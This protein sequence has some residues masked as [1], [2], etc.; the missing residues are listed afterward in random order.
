MGLS[1]YIHEESVH[2]LRDPEIIVPV[3]MEVLHPQS[4]VDVGCG[5]GTFLHV[6][7]K[8]GV[9]KILGI[10]GDWVNKEQIAKHIKP[11]KFI[12]VDLE[13]GIEVD[14]KFDLAVCL[15]V[16]EHLEEIHADKIVKNLT[17]LS[18]IIFFS[19]AI[20]GQPGQNHVNLQWP[21]YWNKKFQ[22]FGY[23]FHD[24]LRPIFW[25]KNDLAWWYRQ[26]MFI[27]VKNGIEY[28]LKGFDLYKDSE[29]KSFIHPDFYME[30]ARKLKSLGLTYDSLLSK[31]NS[32][33]SGKSS[34]KTYTKILAKYLFRKFSFKKIC[35]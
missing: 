8:H 27:V 35:Y 30:G 4:V 25:N 32:I 17:K 1:N 16:M 28:K 5:T 9:K 20:P 2:N 7:E 13:K 6:F 29:I 15:E 10:D 23:T 3:I 31:Y 22:Q 33:L 24:V 34:L 26:N 12:I 11:D 14:E 21:V 19:A 18:D